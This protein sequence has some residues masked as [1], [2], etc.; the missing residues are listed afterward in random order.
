MRQYALAEAQSLRP[1]SSLDGAVFLLRDVPSG[2]S[3][4]CLALHEEMCI[5]RQQTRLGVGFD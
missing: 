2:A 4:V 5:V 1:Y 3:I